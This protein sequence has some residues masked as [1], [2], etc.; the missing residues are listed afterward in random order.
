MREWDRALVRMQIWGQCSMVC[1]ACCVCVWLLMVSAA[2]CM[3]QP[4]CS[5]QLMAR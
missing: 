3:L 2:R 5:L 1:V 4:I